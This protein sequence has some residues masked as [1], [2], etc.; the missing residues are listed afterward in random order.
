MR[1]FTQAARELGLPAPRVISYEEL[2]A[3]RGWETLRELDLLRIDSPGEN[4]VVTRGLIALGGGP[5][6][7]TLEHGEIAYLKPYHQGYL[8]FLQRVAGV[9][10]LNH[11]DEI[12]LMFDKWACHQMFQDAGLP[13]PPSQLAPPTLA[14]LR[15]SA[16][17]QGRL[18]LK[19]LHGSS[20]SGVCALRWTRQRVQMFAP[21]RLVEGRLFNDLRVSRF[22]CWQE[23]EAILDRLLPQG[24]LAER[25]I[26][27]L[28]LREGVVD[29]R[30]LVVAGEARHT[31]VRQ[32]DH[33]M[34]NLHLGNR[35]GCLDELRTRLGDVRW[36]EALTLAERAA[37][38]FPRCLSAGVD[39][40]LDSRGKALIG[41]INAFGDLLPGLT[42]RG[43]SAYT[44]ILKARNAQSCPV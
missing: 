29:L 23:I 33:P 12:G 7:A 25:W 4:D 22:E 20:S 41:E 32:S 11:P 9:R 40:L 21:L 1:D 42:H 27:K 19:P 34:T 37:A 10:C 39:I 15:A 36:R 38:C 16:P 28:S 35:R 13:R 26:P 17:A 31:V 43:E 6:K 18:F 30:V 24:M 3:G 44:A 14:A 8:C 2:L 5:R